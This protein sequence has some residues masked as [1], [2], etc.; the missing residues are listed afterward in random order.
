MNRID[1]D[2]NLIFHYPPGAGGKFLINSLG[3]SEYATFQ[4]CELIQRQLSG[5]FSST[6]KLAYLLD[7]I[8][9]A[10]IF[11]YWDDLG[12]GCSQTFSVAPYNTIM[13]PNA[14][15]MSALKT[16][17]DRKLMMFIAG[18][19]TLWPDTICMAW[20]SA[21][22]VDFTNFNKFLSLRKGYSPCDNFS[23]CLAYDYSWES[24]WY[25]EKDV[26][27]SH[28]KQLY[29]QMNLP[30]FNEE[31]IATYYDEWIAAILK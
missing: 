13:P 20:P 7:K 2:R 25:L 10:R 17:C 19:D 6:N 16:A 21:K 28:I 22:L 29:E 1:S 12:L 24:D 31:F 18:H 4:S 15:Q 30:D 23:P 11:Q 9:N 14:W 3:L 27:L 8:N 5:Q 26:T